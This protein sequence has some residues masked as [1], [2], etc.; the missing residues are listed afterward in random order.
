MDTELNIDFKRELFYPEL[1][2][3]NNIKILKYF[4]TDYLSERAKFDETDPELGY[5]YIFP[6]IELSIWR[7]NIDD[8]FFSTIGIGQKGYY[9]ET[10]S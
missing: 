2:N 1:R 6:D 4:K 9:S 5:S 3:F 7:P 8:E 10:I